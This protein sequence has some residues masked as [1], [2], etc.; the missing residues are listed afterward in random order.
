MFKA[1]LSRSTDAKVLK[2]LDFV[3]DKGLIPNH[4]DPNALFGKP[5]S[6]TS[7]LHCATAAGRTALVDWLLAHGASASLR[8][9]AGETPLHVGVDHVRIGKGREVFRRLLDAGAPT[10]AT[11]A[12][13][14]TA[15]DRAQRLG[16]DLNKV[17]ASGGGGGGS[18]P[19]SAA[20]SRRA[21]LAVTGSASA[22]AAAATGASA[23]AGPAAA[24]TLT[25]TPH[26]EAAAA[27]AAIEARK[28]Q[29]QQDLKFSK[30]AMK[31]LSTEFAALVAARDDATQR[32]TLERGLLTQLAEERTARLLTE[33]ALHDK[34]FGDADRVFL[35]YAADAHCALVTY[36]LLRA[37]ANPNKQDSVG[38]TALHLAARAAGQG[39]ASALRVVEVL[40]ADSRTDPALRSYMTGEG[41]LDAA[42]TPAVVAQLKALDRGKELKIRVARMVAETGVLQ[43]QSV[44][45]TTAAAKAA[46]ETK[47]ATEEAQRQEKLMSS[48]ALSV[49]SI[50]VVP[51]LVFLG[52]ALSDS[53][54]AGLVSASAEGSSSSS[55]SGA[56]AGV[57]GAA[58]GVAGAR[59]GLAGRRGPA[60]LGSGSG[61]GGAASAGARRPPFYASSRRAGLPPSSRLAAASASGAAGS[62]G[63][64]STPAVT[65]RSLQS[66]PV[67]GPGG[68]GAGATLVPPTVTGAMGPGAMRTASPMPWGASAAAKRASLPGAAASGS[69][70]P[71]GPVAQARVGQVNAAA[72]AL[73]A[74]AAAAV[75]VAASDPAQAPTRPASSAAPGSGAVAAAA[76]AA[77]ARAA[78]AAASSTPDALLVA[79]TGVELDAARAYAAFRALSPAAAPLS[80]AA[81]EDIVAATGP[82]RS[83]AAVRACMQAFAVAAARYAI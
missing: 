5:G 69:A 13:G 35:H 14:E 39:D 7:L 81:V 74:A 25:V 61:I 54:G 34:T 62:S 17:L 9:D 68:A 47:A 32:D 10:D 55:S 77:A 29:L 24:V 1:A 20:P 38:E 6:Q 4:F 45:V 28:K 11:D 52:P 64:A 73:S 51:K 41:A 66:R 56:A 59:G 18:M 75:P 43:E 23:A 31:Q 2:D 72:I 37:K 83:A 79:D 8:N 33:K 21:S 76:A 46:A 78:A 30:I 12:A 36:A 44:A 27:A 58:G 26:D 80:A 15:A 63:Y 67:A 57:G 53:Y 48:N 71:G 3:A 42:V 82:L 40:L 22:T 16:F 50:N 70:L 19:S 49:A 65:P 60:T